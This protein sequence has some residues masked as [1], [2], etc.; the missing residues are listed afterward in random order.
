MSAGAVWTF[1]S[2]NDPDKD[3]GLDHQKL[4]PLFSN[5]AHVKKKKKFLDSVKASGLIPIK[6][7]KSLFRLSRQISTWEKLKR[8][9]RVIAAYKI[10]LR[11]YVEL[12]MFCFWKTDLIVVV[13][14]LL[15]F[16]FIHSLIIIK[17]IILFIYRC[18]LMPV[19][20]NQSVLQL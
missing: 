15:G 12:F 5:H 2:T 14:I 6:Y 4:L 10:T 7:L 8:F 20:S 17:F 19:R 16:M 18:E 1:K 9:P 11:S 13:V 3:K